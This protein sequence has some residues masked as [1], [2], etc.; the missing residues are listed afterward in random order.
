MLKV[1]IKTNQQNVG[2]SGQEFNQAQNVP[3]LGICFCIFVL[4]VNSEYTLNF[5]CHRIY[6]ENMKEWCE[7][8]LEWFDIMQISAPK[9]KTILVFT[10]VD[11]IDMA[12]IEGEIKQV[13]QELKALFQKK[14]DM[15]KRHFQESDSDINRKLYQMHI[16]NCQDIIDQLKQDDESLNTIPRISCLPGKEKSVDVIVD[17]MLKFAENL[18]EEEGLAPTDLDLFKEIGTLGLKK[19][20]ILEDHVPAA[21]DTPNP[22]KQVTGTT[23]RSESAED[24]VPTHTVEKTQKLRQQ[25]ITLTKVREIFRPILMKHYPDKD[26]DLEKEL[27]K[28]L[29]NLKKKGLI[30]Y[31]TE[32]KKLADIIFNDISTMVNILRCIFHH[33]LTKF[34]KFMD[35]HKELRKDIKL[36]QKDYKKEV[37]Y[38]TLHAIISRGLVELLLKKTDCSLSGDIVLELLAT[39]NIAFPISDDCNVAFVP[40]F[41]RDCRPDSVVD[42]EKKII[43]CYHTTLALHCVLKGQI[44]RPY[45]NEL[46]VKLYGE[47]Y[48][49]CVNQKQNITWADGLSASLGCYDSN[50]LLLYDS[51]KQ[52]I[53]F[54]IQANI[55]EIEGHHFLFDKVKFIDNE[56]ISIRD[57]RYEG[58]VIEFEFICTDCSRKDRNTKC[59]WDIQLCLDGSESKQTTMKCRMGNVIPCALLQPLPE[60]KPY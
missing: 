37:Q 24:Q 38:L 28:S 45:F 14:Q 55:E 43:N 17:L 25:H 12:Y 9:S 3:K 52:I 10:Q 15:E 11:R 5:L 20:M 54:I 18:K 53:E 56:S 35:L 44:P 1:T 41:L 19:D 29:E 39:L 48:Q 6:A 50:L 47:M 58:L 21:N 42:E 8:T 31:F 4:Q 26:P 46:M 34:P 23:E 13:K 57:A 33:E 59:V 36:T 49:K 2:V 7:A 32:R 40:Y 60:G 30:R 22:E 51:R 16:Q 27:Q